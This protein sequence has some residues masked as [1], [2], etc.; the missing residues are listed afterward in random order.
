MAKHFN[1]N[2]AKT[3]RETEPKYEDGL[4]LRNG[5]VI[6]KN[7]DSLGRRAKNAENAWL[8]KNG[9]KS[10]FDKPKRSR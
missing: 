4:E 10:A 6:H 7:L 2:R 8:K 9:M 1:W 5:E 3:F